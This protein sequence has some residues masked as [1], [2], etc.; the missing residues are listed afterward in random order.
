MGSSFQVA[1]DGRSHSQRLSTMRAFPRWIIRVGNPFEPTFH[2]IE[3]GTL[4]GQEGSGIVFSVA[5]G[6]CPCNPVVR[7]FSPEL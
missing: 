1:N 7:S 6:V 2:L 3:P 4:V 5:W